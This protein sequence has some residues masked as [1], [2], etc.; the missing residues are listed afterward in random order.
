[1]IYYII[2]RDTLFVLLIARTFTV[3]NSTAFAPF[4]FFFI[5][6][7][8]VVLYHRAY[9]SSTEATAHSQ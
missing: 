9:V 4:F 3:T 5:K 1:M 8:G 7:F 6:P 2:L